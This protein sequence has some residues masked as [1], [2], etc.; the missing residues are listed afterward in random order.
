MRFQIFRSIG[1]LAL[2]ALL[3]ASPLPTGTTP[4]ATQSPLPDKFL[5]AIGAQ[6]SVGQFNR[7]YG[8]AVAPDGTV[9]VAD[10]WNNRIQRFSA[11]G[12][13]MGRWGSQGSGDGQFYWLSGVAVAPDGTIYVAESGNHRIQAFGTTYPTTWRGEYF[14]NR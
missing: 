6:A 4:T 2:L 10:T 9:Y 1:W 13:F 12:D 5:F 7:P 3:V 14:A 8:V 11:T